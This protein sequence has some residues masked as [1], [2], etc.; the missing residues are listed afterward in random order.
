LP[1]PAF[2]V[3]VNSSCNHSAK[4]YLEI[5]NDLQSLFGIAVVHEITDRAGWTT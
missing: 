1:Q 4:V 2:T 5:A 3:P